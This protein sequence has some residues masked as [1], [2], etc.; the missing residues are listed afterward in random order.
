MKNASPPPMLQPG[1]GSYHSPASSHTL[2][3]SSGYHARTEGATTPLHASL[4]GSL[5]RGD[6]V[7]FYSVE[8][9]GL[10]GATFSSVFSIL[11]LLYLTAPLLAST[12]TPQEQLGVSRLTELPFCLAFLIGLLSDCVPICGLRRKAYV[13][14]GLALNAVATTVIAVAAKYMETHVAR[15][16]RTGAVGIIIVMIAV[17]GFGCMFLN[18][19]VHTRTIELSQREP[20]ATRGH[21]QASYL[22]FR[23]IVS[24]TTYVYT[25]F[26]LGPTPGA[27]PRVA[28]STALY[29][30][31]AISLAPLPLILRYW[32]E[33]FYSLSDPFLTRAKICWRIL[34]QTAVWRTLLFFSF[35]VL[36]LNIRFTTPAATVLAWAG[37]A[38]DN[39]LVTRIITE[40][41]MLCGVLLWR[42]GFLN[43]PWRSFFALAPLL[44]IVPSA[45][46][47]AIV[48]Y[49]LV[50]NRY[51]YRAIMALTG[52]ADG[53]SIVSNLIPLTE[54]VQEGSEGALVGIASTMQRLL[55]IFVTTNAQG[56]FQAKNFYNPAH[57]TRADDSHAHDVVFGTLLFNYALNAL[58]IF[59]LLLLPRQKLD[60]QH[61][62]MYG[63]FTKVASSALV[64]GSVLLLLYSV[65]LNVMTIIP[66]T[67]CSRIVGGAGC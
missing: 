36:F 43:R 14:I 19:C 31:V 27:P 42:Y 11:V 13:L 58:S 41:S 40:V 57:V 52:I 17:A 33:E 24:F 1:F 45:I 37:A 47:S 59:G 34:Q 20:L 28:L 62:R 9:A 21:L 63:G 64:A 54:I 50:R 39:A 7:S 4:Y 67:S 53:I 32:T 55:A 65:F 3:N 46:T 44:L 2:N 38:K 23:R 25:Y 35:F 15:H 8:C 49:G 5:R 6:V 61:M 26:V 66:S 48:S 30:S 16:E 10:V 51:A 12:L 29:I 22:I 60:A 18:V 56:I